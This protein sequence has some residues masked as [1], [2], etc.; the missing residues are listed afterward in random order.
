MFIGR[1]RE[2]SLLRKRYKSS[3]FELVGIYGRRRVGKTSLINEFVRDLPC[4]YCMAVEDDREA[5]LRVLS[6]AVF[7]LRGPN[8]GVDALAD[9]PVYPNFESAIEAAFEATRSR[10]AVLVFD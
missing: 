10:R 4:G 9:A 6:R 5:N 7:S 3:A 1:E 2:L 8:T